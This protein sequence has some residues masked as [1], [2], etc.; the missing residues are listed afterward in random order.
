MAPTHRI[1]RLQELDPE[2]FYELTAAFVAAHWDRPEATL[3]VAP[4]SPDRRVE[5][6]LPDGSL[7]VAFQYA[8]SAVVSEGALR[9]I[10][11]MGADAAITTAEFAPGAETLAEDESVELIDGERFARLL[12]DYEIPIPE[13]EGRDLEALVEEL[14]G[15][16][17]GTLAETAREVVGTIDSAGNFEYGLSRADYSTDLDVIPAGGAQPIAKLRFSPA[18]LGLYVRRE[19]WER[20]IG[21]SAHGDHVPPDLHERVRTA[22]EPLG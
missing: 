12:A 22:I 8:A 18:G 16:W 11:S 5:I 20:V 15:H 4:P 13:S 7:V 21:V 1:E 17:S 19:R 2:A 9:E 14:S 10:D 3:A 6:R